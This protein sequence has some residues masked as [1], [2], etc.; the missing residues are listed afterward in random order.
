[1]WLIGTVIAAFFVRWIFNVVL[2]RLT[3]KSKTIYDDRLIEALGTPVFL[4][5]I[6]GGVYAAGMSISLPDTAVDIGS[7]S[8]ITIALLIWW[9]GLSQIIELLFSVL[10]THTDADRGGV[11]PFI[12]IAAK[13]ILAAIIILTGMGTWGINITPALASAG[14]VGVAL[15]VAAKDT[16]ANIFGGISVFFDNPYKL[17][18]YVIIKDQYRGEVIDIGMR[19]TKIKTRDNV[20]L[21]VPNSVMVTDAVVN[22]TGFDPELRVRIPV[23]IAYGTDIDKAEEVL[24]NVMKNHKEILQN[25]YPSRV[26]FRKF[27]DS[28]IELEVLGIIGKPVNRGRITHELIKDIYKALTKAKITIPFPQR[29]VHLKKT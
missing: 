9:I 14:I 28:G 22:E 16:V 15:A 8:I 10:K 6:L 19:S 18:D 24:L 29:D 1:M 23:S 7:K 25:S 11:L 20:L 4:S 13:L 5:T 17:G 3:R 12:D 26:R 2:R 27:G 21:T